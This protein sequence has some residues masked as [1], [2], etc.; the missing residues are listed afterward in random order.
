MAW[1]SDYPAQRRVSKNTGDMSSGYGTGDSPVTLFT[2]TGDVICK[3]VAAV[4][5]ALTSDLSGGTLEV[6]VAGNTAILLAQATA[7]G[8]SL[9]VGTSW[10]D[11]TPTQKGDVVS[12]TADVVIANGENII[13]TIATSNITGGVINFYCVYTPLSTTGNIVA[14]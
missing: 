2:V 11:A 3:V 7:N 12:V 8:T 14:A 13:L 6:G 1:G 9:A 5:T 10:T 4:S